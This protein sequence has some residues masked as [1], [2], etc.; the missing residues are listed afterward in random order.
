MSD[1]F[2]GTRAV[3]ERHAFDTG[4]LA[5]W[6]RANVEG[7][8]GDL[9]VEQFKGGQSNPTYLLSAATGNTCCGA[10][11]PASCCPRRTRSTAS[12]ASSPRWRRPTL[13]VAKRYALC[14]DDA[15]IGTAFY[16]MDCVEG[17][18]LWDPALPGHVAPA[19]R[20]AHLR[21]K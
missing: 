3:S 11:R 5:D 21:P 20:A 15:V 12:I 6:L 4:R 8:S 10:S 2:T 17:R 16:M 13:P 1:K 18:V 14:E 7:F 9:T 19:E